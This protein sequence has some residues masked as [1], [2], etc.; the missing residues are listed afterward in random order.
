MKREKRKYLYQTFCITFQ[1]LFILYI[2]YFLKYCCV[3]VSDFQ[4]YH[5]YYRHL[6]TKTT[7]TTLSH[8]QTYHNYFPRTTT[9]KPIITT[10]F[11]LPQPLPTTPNKAT[12][13]TTHCPLQTSSHYHWYHPL[14]YPTQSCLVVP[15]D[16]GLDVYASTQ[17]ASETQRAIGQVL[18]IPDNT[19]VENTSIR[20]DRCDNSRHE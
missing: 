10:S 8:L 3:C 2:Y 17:W 6:H 4:T 7:A 5:I 14:P 1:S 15:T 20:W 13:A 9:Y 12:T 18:G 19:W 16:I 11:R